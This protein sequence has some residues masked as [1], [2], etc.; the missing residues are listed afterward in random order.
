MGEGGDMRRVAVVVALLVCLAAASAAQPKGAGAAPKWD[1]SG[2]GPLPH[3]GIA[4]VDMSAD[5]RF[6]AVG[7]IAAP[8]DPNVFL[9][10]AKGRIVAQHEAGLRWIDRVAVGGAGQFLAAV[11]GT[12]SGSAGD[13]PAAFT[14][15]ANG[16]ASIKTMPA[17]RGDNPWFFHYGDHS[18]HL[19]TPLRSAGG[20]PVA[21]VDNRVVWLAAPGG[22]AGRQVRFARPAGSVVTAFAAATGG[23][24]V[25]G[26]SASGTDGKK[27][28][29]NLFVV[30]P[31]GE[32]PLRS[33]PVCTDA[34]AA[35]AMEEARHGPPAPIVGAKKVWAPLAVA[36]DA[37]RGRVVAADYQGWVRRGVRFM[38]SRPTVHVY[39]RRG[40]LIRRFGPEG[41]AKPFWCELAFSS[42]GASVLAWP[43]NWACRG[44]AGQAILPADEDIRKLH[45]LDIA[46]GKARAI[47]LPAAISSVAHSAGGTTAV[48]CWNGRVYLLDSSFKLAGARAGGPRTGAPCLV[49]ISRDGRRILAAGTDGAVRML[50]GAGRELWR[51]DL[52]RAAR[53]GAKPW[54]KNQKAERIAAGIWRTNGR[55]AHSDMGSQYLVEAPDGLIIIDANSGHSF[56]QN[57][58]R[59]RGAGLDP[60]KVRYVLLTHEHGDHAPGAYLWRVVTGARVVAG[61]ETAYVLRHCL[62]GHTGYGFHPPGPVD[63]V[64]TKD[65]E[66]KLSG[67]AVRAV[68]VPGHTWGSTAWVFRKEGKAYAATGDLIM[69]GGVLGYDGS[70][71]FSAK[72]LLASLK[73]L[74]RMDLHVVLGGHGGG[75]AR[76][77]LGNGIGVGEATGWGRTKP[78]K[79]DPLHGFVSKDC[80]VAAWLE[81]IR[82]AAFGDVNGDG[83][84]DL[85]VL[86]GAAA[87]GEGL[88][89]K[90]YLNKGG[91]FGAADVVLDLPDWL[92]AG[93]SRLLIGHV[94]KDRVADLF[95]H[96][97]SRGGDRAT[98]FMSRADKLQYRPVEIRQSVRTSRIGPA[99]FNGDGLTDLVLLNRFAADQ[100]AYQS[101]AGTFRSVRAEWRNGMDL[102]L[103]DVNGDG[104][105][106]LVTSGGDV[107]LRRPNGSLAPPLQ[108]EAPKE[109]TWV[110]AGDFD[111]DGRVELV[112]LTQ[113]K[114]QDGGVE[115]RLFENTGRAA[116]PFA[117]KPTRRFGIPG[118]AVLRCGPIVA[119]WN[120]DGIADVI[121]AASGRKGALIIPG[122][123][124]R[125]LEPARA[126]RIR[127][128]YQVH[129]DMPM[130]VADF[131]GD[132]KPDLAAFAHSH[133]TVPGV[134]IRFQKPR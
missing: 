82:S 4:C 18:N 14:F 30:G 32:A 64:V 92:R 123:A 129:H 80:L 37:G 26:C 58:A 2:V 8:G 60:M 45:V 28:P 87:G 35:P 11:C 67:L 55:L 20:R 29:C 68:R 86:V 41:F 133:R 116:R 15:A 110:A 21:V 71:D 132:G 125:G 119:D 78:R 57:W 10:D 115:A 40:K 120:G 25:V 31:D 108:L 34:E 112:L 85:A 39:D 103:V 50:D 76:E 122:R 61:R 109:W 24:V 105:K 3:Q 38:P 43:H 51:T 23:Q 114:S 97:R 5:G 121:L 117:A 27:A 69:P 12:P 47:D 62:P 96:G 74:A 44:L 118:A 49:R 89:V 36:L 99:D 88:T 56:E 131:N 72:A 130:S 33:R 134:F 127:F 77:F 53:G 128:D 102:R 9:L 54:T 6:A 70:V 95:V 81:K 83:R 75:I 104:K 79:P 42:D 124:G 19:A 13:R 113:A 17:S 101:R 22:A 91:S 7:T 46:T 98:L 126:V 106:D 84:P 111:K 63:I 1:A 73:K 93:D 48:A 59:I 94:N 52:N 65:R 16:T 66:L 107:L 100:I 90:V